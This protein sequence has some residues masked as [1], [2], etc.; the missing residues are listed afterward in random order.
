MYH[1]EAEEKE[2][3]YGTAALCWDYTRC[4]HR[5]FNSYKKPSGSVIL[6]IADKFVQIKYVA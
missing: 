6:S 1:R 2:N 4:F 3:I 5:A